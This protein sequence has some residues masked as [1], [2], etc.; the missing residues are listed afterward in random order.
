M[1]I[2]LQLYIYPWKFKI[3]MW[4]E[5]NLFLKRFQ[6][7]LATNHLSRNKI[8]LYTCFS[9]KNYFISTQ[10]LCKHIHSM[11][12]NHIKLC[13][14]MLKSRN[15]ENIWSYIYLIDSSLQKNTNFTLSDNINVTTQMKKKMFKMQ[16]DCNLYVL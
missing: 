9:Y 12:S 10:H 8:I 4:P 16:L 5:M 7:T 3:Y 6:F 1:Y 11:H 2:L 14:I 15:L 13:I